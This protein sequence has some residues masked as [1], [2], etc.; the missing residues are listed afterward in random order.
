MNTPTSTFIKPTVGRVV[1]FYPHAN[2][3]EAGFEPTSAGEPLAAVIARVWSDGM[4]NLTVFD[5][6]GKPHSRTS[7]ELL[8]EPGPARAASGGFCT[9]MP[10]QKGQAKAQEK[11]ADAAAASVA[12][13][14]A[15][16]TEP[17]ATI[18]VTAVGDIAAGA[19]MRV[20]VTAGLA[21]PTSAEKPPEADCSGRI[22]F[23]FGDAVRHL[24]AGRRVARSGWNGKG[25][26]I[27]LNK[28]S[29]D[30]TKIPP[31]TVDGIRW[32][33]DLFEN[34]DTGTV[35]RLPNINM[36]AASGATVTS[37]LA[38]QADMLAE[39]WVVVE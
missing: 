35:T 1:W 12:T 28:G 16:R 19:A 23:E 7:V 37:W 13:P 3:G 6:S 27:Y 31:S 36:R 30:G 32:S 26:F 20:N 14:P 11:Q 38:S 24:K 22:Q 9:W 17:D 29:M 15:A 18:Y 34:G 5:A 8:Q 39:D 25:M 4:V 33:F 21:W 10:F 2:S